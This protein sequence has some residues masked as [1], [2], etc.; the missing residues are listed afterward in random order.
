MQTNK[1]ALQT[2]A[3]SDSILEQM[4]R[5]T[6]SLTFVSSP[7]TVLAILFSRLYSG[8]LEWQM[9][10]TYHLQAEGWGWKKH[11][12]KANKTPR[13]PGTRDKVC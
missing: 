4:A 8:K 12:H 2:K 11:L 13:I 7:T 1:V 3:F 9:N 10:H 5:V 6:A